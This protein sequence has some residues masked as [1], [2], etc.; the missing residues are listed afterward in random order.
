ME[1]PNHHEHPELWFRPSP[2]MPLTVLLPFLEREDITATFRLGKRDGTHPKGYIPGT[3]ATIRLFDEEGKE[4]LCKQVRIT[5]VISKPLSDFAA[6]ELTNSA[7]Y[8]TESVRQDL[9]FFE[10]RPVALD[11]IASLVAFSYLNHKG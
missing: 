11:E 3:I 10:G 6:A 4:R 5:H 9:S 1:K 2:A 8:L 7:C